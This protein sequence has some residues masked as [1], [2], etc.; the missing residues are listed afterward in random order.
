M[1]LCATDADGMAV[2]LI[3]SNY[4][5][6]GSGITVAGWG[7][8]LH[9]RGAGFWLDPD[10][11]GVVG[12]GRQPPHTLIPA[13][14]LRDGRPWL[15]FGAMG[16]DG[17]AQTHVQL[18]ARLVDGDGD[19]D[20]GAALGAPRWFVSPI[21]WEVVAEPGF[22]LA[23]L[24]GLRAKGHK[25]HVTAGPDSLMGHANAIV[26][27]PAGGYQGASDPRTEGACIGW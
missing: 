25:V 24:D 23:V 7:I 26:F 15:V 21:G 2:S 16:G 11:V 14:A 20:L 27:D 8:N 13:M 9:N 22:D 1:Y 17:Q 12:P 4:R 6:F 10:A 5:G 3:Q 18:L 19:A